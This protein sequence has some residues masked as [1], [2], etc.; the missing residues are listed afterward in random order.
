M[1][2]IDF[3]SLMLVVY[4]LVDDWY[5]A[6]LRPGAV[7]HARLSAPPRAVKPVAAEQ[8]K[9]SKKAITRLR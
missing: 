7:N 6:L 8:P 9:E 2:S 1:T 3:S 4:V 5:Q